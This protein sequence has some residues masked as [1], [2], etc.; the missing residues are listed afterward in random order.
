M[1]QDSLTHAVVGTGVRAV[2]RMNSL[3]VPAQHQIHSMNCGGDKL[4][5]FNSL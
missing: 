4:T 1:R 2:W 5:Q 3:I